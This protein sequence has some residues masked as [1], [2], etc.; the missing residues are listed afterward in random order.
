MLKNYQEKETTKEPQQPQPQYQEQYKEQPQ[1][2]YERSLPQQQI[3]Q[4][5]QISDNPQMQNYYEN[6]LHQQSQLQ[7]QRAQQDP[8]DQLTSQMHKLTLQEEAHNEYLANKKRN[9]SI[10]DNYSQQQQ[11]QQPTKTFDSDYANRTDK[12]K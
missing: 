6:L 2:Q 12:Q 9:G 10:F 11:Q 3:Q 8:T 5:K 4:S 7:E 1:P